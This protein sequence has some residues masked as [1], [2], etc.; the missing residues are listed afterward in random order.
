MVWRR[1]LSDCQA[2]EHPGQ[3]CGDLGWIVPWQV[4]AAFVARCCAKF[5][6]SMMDHLGFISMNRREVIGIVKHV[7]Q[8][9]VSVVSA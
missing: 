1:E 2:G 3:L 4:S 5:D 6:G 7:T 9:Y 8:D